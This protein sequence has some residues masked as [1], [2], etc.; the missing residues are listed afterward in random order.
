MP[1]L[2]LSFNTSLYYFFQ[3][4]RASTV[5][6]YLSISNYLSIYR[7]RYREREREN[8]EIFIIGIGSSDHGN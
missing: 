2:I 1:Y 3:R 5:S 6:I 8:K 7:Y 4:N